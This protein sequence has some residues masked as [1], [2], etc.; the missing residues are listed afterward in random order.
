M[1]AR[2]NRRDTITLLGGVAA[3]RTR[4]AARVAGDWVSERQDG[5]L[6]C[7]GAGFSPP[8]P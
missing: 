4:A 7:L 8:W 6:G 5:G 1:I 2:I 3:C